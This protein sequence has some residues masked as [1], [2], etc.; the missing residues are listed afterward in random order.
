MFKTEVAKTSVDRRL[1]LGFDAGCSTCSNLAK[2]IE[3]EG[4]EKIEVRSLHDPQMEHWRKQALGEN[5]P[6]A[7]TLVEVK[8]DK[9]KAWTRVQMGVRLSYVLGPVAMWRVMQ[10]LGEASASGEVETSPASKTIAGFT[11]GQFLKGV[12]G[13]LVA[14]SAVASVGPLSSSAQAAEDEAIQPSKISSFSGRRKNRITREVMEYQD[15]KNVASNHMGGI[16]Q[17]SV[18]DTKAGIHTLKNGNKQLIVVAELPGNYILIYH[19][20]R[21]QKEEGQRKKVVET[22]ASLF[23]IDEDKKELVLVESSAN[24][25]LDIPMDEDP[26]ADPP[27]RQVSRSQIFSRRCCRGCRGRRPRRYRFRKCTR[28]SNRCIGIVCALCAPSCASIFGC[29]A[30]AIFS[31]GIGSIATCCRRRRRECRTCGPRYN[32]C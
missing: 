6:W 19:E 32:A 17:R 27:G 3:E 26:D 12:S 8:D 11:R 9:V 25:A 16:S 22:E 20:T 4:N 30:C 18:T 14:I 24:G 13:S 28:Y 23:G 2:R 29:V 31:C 5:A 10:A 21:H 15:V 7:P 1:V